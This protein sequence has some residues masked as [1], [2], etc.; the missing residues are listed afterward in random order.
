[1]PP[2]RRAEAGARVFQVV[3]KAAEVGGRLGLE[4]GWNSLQWTAG[5]APTTTVEQHQLDVPAGSHFEVAYDCYKQRPFANGVSPVRLTGQ[6]RTLWEG[7]FV[8]EGQVVK[9]VIYVRGWCGPTIRP[10]S[11][12]LPPSP[13]LP[14]G[15]RSDRLKIVSSAG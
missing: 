5:G 8:K 7:R 14:K 9:R 12:S 4:A 2:R 13:R 6:F 10:G 1:M 3:F 11:S 15:N